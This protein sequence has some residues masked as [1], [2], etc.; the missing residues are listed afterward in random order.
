[1]T[2]ERILE[3]YLLEEREDEPTVKFVRSYSSPTIEMQ[4]EALKMCL[5]IIQN[6][7]EPP[8]PTAKLTWRQAK[9]TLMSAYT[10]VNLC[11]KDEPRWIPAPQPR[12]RKE[13]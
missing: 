8:E 4:A 9:Q 10:E 6:V 11:D 2:V 1:M 5:D 3:E 12:K 7:P 13:R